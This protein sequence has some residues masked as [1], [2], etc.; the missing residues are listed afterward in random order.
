MMK[1]QQQQQQS[2]T[3]SRR[4]LH[5]ILLALHL[6]TPTLFVSTFVRAAAVVPPDA[7]GRRKEDRQPVH[8]RVRGVGGG[9]DRVFQDHSQVRQQQGSAWLFWAAGWL[10]GMYMVDWWNLT[11]VQGEE[12]LSDGGLAGV[13]E[14]VHS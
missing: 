3:I 4:H 10:A 6:L 8:H 7:A 12:K 5:A 11:V 9:E 2:R 14:D 13:D 1:K